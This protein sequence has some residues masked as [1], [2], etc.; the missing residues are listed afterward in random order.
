M[1]VLSL[2]KAIANT[3]KALIEQGYALAHMLEATTNLVDSLGAC[4]KL[5]EE[6]EQLTEQELQAL[7]CSLEGLPDG[8]EL[9]KGLAESAT[10]ELSSLE[11][12]HGG[13]LYDPI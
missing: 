8:L 6:I 4:R 7:T 10:A 5:H 2:F 3:V 9:A 13:T 11:A 1:A 12:I